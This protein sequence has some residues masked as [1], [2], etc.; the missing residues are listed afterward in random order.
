[1][2]SL[3]DLVYLTRPP[4]GDPE[5]AVIFLHGRGADE[6]DLFPLFD[7]L[8]PTRRLIGVTPRG[9][10]SLP[11]GGAHW[12]VLR[13]VGRPDPDTFRAS[14]ALIEGWLDAFLKDQ[15][16]TIDQV[17]LGGFSQGAVMAYSLSLGA[18]RP[19]PAGLIA[20]SGFMPEVPDFLFDL[21]T[22][23][24]FRVAIGHGTHDPM[25]D[26]SFSRQAREVLEE[27]GCDVTYKES[28]MPHTID[29]EYLDFLT[30]WVDATLDL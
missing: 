19:A 12:Y 10:L 28:P 6:R 26:V 5:G 13:D 27:A 14:F 4:A 25:I 22:R 30:G 8:D 1:M 11:P 23:S 17:I 18:G 7:I 16:L 3:E 2:A 15:G 20:F 29:P 24:D 21:D 9:P